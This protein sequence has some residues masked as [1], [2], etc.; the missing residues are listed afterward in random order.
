MLAGRRVTSGGLGPFSTNILQEILGLLRSIACHA[1]TS[2]NCSAR[3]TN[4]SIPPTT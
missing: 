4:T 1:G 3:G 2:P